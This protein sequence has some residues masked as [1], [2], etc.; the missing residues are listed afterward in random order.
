ME[1]EPIPAA[2]LPLTGICIVDFTK[3]LP[4]PWCTQLLADMGAEVIKVEAPDIGD[5]SRHNPPRQREHSAYF[6]SVNRNKR[7]I[8]LDLR[9]ASGLE[10]ARRLIGWADVMLESFAVGGAARL[11]IDYQSARMI[12][13]DIIY[14]SISGF[15][16][17]GPLAASSGHDLVVQAMTGVL[18]T[19][20]AGEMPQFQAA[21]YAGGAFATIAI[22]SALYR[23]RTSGEGAFLDVAMF[24]SLLAMSTAALGQGLARASGGSGTPALEAW[25]RNPR[26]AIYA[27]LDQ[28]YVGVSLLEPGLWAKFCE[29]IGRPDLVFGDERPEDRHSDH[30]ERAALYR[31]AITNY[32]AVRT[33]D[34]I[35]Q[36]MR[37]RDIPVCPVLNADEALASPQA[38]ARGMVYWD[39]DP[40]DGKVLRIGNPL[41]RAGLADLHRRPP[42]RLGAH[43]RDILDELGL[44][45][46][47]GK[48][49]PA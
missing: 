27:T 19:A 11:R 29:A 36:A 38:L 1:Y 48:T 23:R 49:E 45:T 37:A 3:L 26:Y 28:R 2:V 5:P 7:S 13:P 30:G 43:T 18:S 40:H 33:M 35:D 25:G 9:S 16:Q 14:C 42:P 22:L 46:E 41:A 4:G 8:E 20:G 24:D 39:T 34:E 47:Q 12:N 17:D 32:C 6:A 10:A 15:G 21:D 44:A 31:T